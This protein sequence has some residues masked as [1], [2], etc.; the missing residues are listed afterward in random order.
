MQVLICIL[1]QIVLPN[2]E[3]TKHRLY[4]QK[5]VFISG[6]LYNALL[7]LIQEVK[8]APFDKLAKSL[9]YKDSIL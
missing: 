7:K 9:I 3:Q 4:L 6:K 1:I 5:F 8:F 2:T